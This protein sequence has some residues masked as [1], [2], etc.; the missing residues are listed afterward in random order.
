MKDNP[1]YWTNYIWA[2]QI[3][4]EFYLRNMTRPISLGV[5]PFI[6]RY[7]S[8]EEGFR[9][10]L[11]YSPEHTNGSGSDYRWF[12]SVVFDS[13]NRAVE[14]LSK[15]ENGNGNTPYN[16]Y[17]VSTAISSDGHTAR[18]YAGRNSASSKFY[19]V[20]QSFDPQGNLIEILIK[21]AKGGNPSPWEGRPGEG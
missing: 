16:Y 20:V 19:V 2:N 12:T 3:D 15:D 8:P 9:D 1:N 14:E 18:C 5:E 4:R 10:L 17:D 11:H 21:G 7:G 13:L 6:Y